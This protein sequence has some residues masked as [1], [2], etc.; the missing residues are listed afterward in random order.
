MKKF[1]VILGPDGCGKTTFS[2]ELS[3]QLRKS[4]TKIY[5]FK[6]I[7]PE[8][9]KFIF[10]KRKKIFVRKHSGMVKP[11]LPLHSSLLAFWYGIDFFLGHF[12]KLFSKYNLIICVRSYHDFFYQRAHRKLNVNIPKFF[13]SIGPKPDLI[14]LLNRNPKQIYIDKNELTEDEICIQYERIRQLLGNEP[15]FIEL[16]LSKDNKGQNEILKILDY[17]N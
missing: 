9:S 12:I 1:I 4:I 7:L 15:N 10:K 2:D 5:T 11:L 16:N 14:I 17:E 13:L 8:L 6:F 3:S